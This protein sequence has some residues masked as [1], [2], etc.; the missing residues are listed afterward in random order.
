MRW[1]QWKW[2]LF[3]IHEYNVPKN[4]PTMCTVPCYVLWIWFRL[5]DGDEGNNTTQHHVNVEWMEWYF[6]RCPCRNWRI[7]YF[8]IDAVWQVWQRKVVVVYMLYVCTIQQHT[9]RRRTWYSNC[10]SEFDFRSVCASVY[11]FFSS[12]NVL[13]AALT[14]AVRTAH[15][16]LSEID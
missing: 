13:L 14:E 5:D 3:A 2:L 7:K 15:A 11:H 12:R 16:T 4:C 8:D 6:I 1:L 9:H 10:R